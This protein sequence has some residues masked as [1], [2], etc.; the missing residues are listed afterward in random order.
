MTGKKWFILML[1]ILSGFLVLMIMIT[2][3]IDPYFHYHAPLDGMSYRLYEERYINDGIARNFDYDAIIIGSSMVENFKTTEMDE[4]FE[5]KSVKLPYSG[6]L[7]QEQSEALD[8][9]LERNPGV[10]QVI[11]CLDYS[12]L[13][14]N[15]DAVSYA[16]LPEYLYND[17]ILDDVSYWFNKDILYRGTAQNIL[18]TIRK[19]LPDNF[20]EYASWEYETG[21]DHILLAYTP[22]EM[23]AEPQ[24]KLE[25][26][27]KE[28][29]IENISKNVLELTRKYPEVKF[30]LYLPVYSIVYWDEE[31]RNGAILPQIEAEEI[32]LSLLIDEDNINVFSFNENTDVATDLSLYNDKYHSNASINSK[33]LIWI[34]NG[35][36]EITKSNLSDHISFVKDF[37]TSYDYEG[38]YK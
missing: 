9:A 4:L 7:F 18:K 33:I 26:A 22:S 27:T 17:I 36:Y 32:T 12:G 16:N 34:K 10:E 1:S 35:E 29:V 23:V 19:E 15:Y 21:L 24:K 37:Y 11:W 31:Y 5:T 38:I 30:Y 3:V 6:A 20:D 14:R 25:S 8:K 28:L 13:I 2:V